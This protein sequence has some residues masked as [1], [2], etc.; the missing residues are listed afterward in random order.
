MTVRDGAENRRRVDISS[1]AIKSE[2][3]IDAG[4]IN[5]R[6]M[7]FVE[8]AY[9][10]KDYFEDNMDNLTRIRPDTIIGILTQQSTGYSA[11]KGK[12]HFLI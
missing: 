11:M 1:I 12:S 8:K 10:L 5:Q 2:E 7:S 6:Y 3:K 4:K 9:A